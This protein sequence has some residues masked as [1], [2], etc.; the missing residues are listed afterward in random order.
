MRQPKNM[1]EM[2]DVTTS[3][4]KL[5]IPTLVEEETL[6]TQQGEI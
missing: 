1:L 6:T 5:I 2:E 3:D 4:R